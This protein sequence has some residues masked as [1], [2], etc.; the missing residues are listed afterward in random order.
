[1]RIFVMYSENMGIQGVCV[2]VGG[3]GG[4]GVGGGGGGYNI[5]PGLAEP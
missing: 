2:C 3:G 5:N 4:W 1:M